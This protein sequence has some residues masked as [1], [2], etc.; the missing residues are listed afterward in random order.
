[1][2]T[3]TVVSVHPACE[4]TV[5]EAVYVPGP[6]YVTIGGFWAEEEEGLPPGNCQFQLLIVPPV[7]VVA[8]A[9]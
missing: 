7:I 3:Y 1:M 9:N 8:S 2:G 6:G 4:T 5:S